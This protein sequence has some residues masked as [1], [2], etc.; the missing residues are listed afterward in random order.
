MQFTQTN[1]HYQELIYR[2]DLPSYLQDE[3]SV[4]YP[5]A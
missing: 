1:G 2:K 5:T 4:Q 3:P